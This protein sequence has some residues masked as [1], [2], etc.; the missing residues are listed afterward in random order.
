MHSLGVYYVSNI[1]NSR[2]TRIS[3]KGERFKDP[4]APSVKSPS[5]LGPGT[6]NPKYYLD[7]NNDR[8]YFL[9]Q[10]KNPMTRRFGTSQR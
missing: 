10:H 5:N 8:V 4:T 3:P 7:T 6:Y 1:E 2:T 9:S